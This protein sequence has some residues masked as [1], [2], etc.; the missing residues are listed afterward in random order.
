MKLLLY[1]IALFLLWI[2]HPYKG[3][4]QDQSDTKIFENFQLPSINAIMDSA[5]LNSPLLKMG[6]L[7]TQIAESEAQ[8]TKREWLKN[9]GMESSY[10]YGKFGSLSTIENTSVSQINSSLAYAKQN[11]YSAGVYMRIP[12][13]EMA[14]RKNK[15]RAEQLK[16]EIAAQEEEKMKNEL[17]EKIIIEYNRAILF[18][19]LLKLKSESL[20]TANLQIVLGEKQFRNGNLNLLDLS[21]LKEGQVKASSDYII[22]LSEAK[23]QL[24]LLEQI[25]GIKIL[26]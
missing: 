25:S 12:L 7:Q 13:S 17:F 9:I 20:E 2:M 18:I 3:I 22:A 4:A 24:M 10:Y 14:D 26:N 15:N 1:I 6:K 21:A 11:T 5:V 19:D 16:I 23:S 8:T